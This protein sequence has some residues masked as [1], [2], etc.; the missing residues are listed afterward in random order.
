MRPP[1]PTRSLNGLLTS[2]AFK[3]SP[4]GTEWR[5]APGI[6]SIKHAEAWGKVVDAAHE[7]EGAK[8]FCQLVSFQFRAWLAL[9]RG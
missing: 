4:Q 8:I 3:V 5:Y 6:Y 7:V 2:V 1:R 9:A